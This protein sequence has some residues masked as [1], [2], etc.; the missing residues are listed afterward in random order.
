MVTSVITTFATPFPTQIT[1]DLLLSSTKVLFIFIFRQPFTNHVYTL[2]LR[3]SKYP[4]NKH[5]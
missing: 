1:S 2:T 4:E 3:K 5:A